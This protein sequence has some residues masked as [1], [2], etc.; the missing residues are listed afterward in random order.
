MARSRCSA[1]LLSTLLLFSASFAHANSS[2]TMFMNFNYLQDQQP[3]GN[4]YNGTGG[5]GTPNYRVSFSSN[6]YGLRSV[7]A[8]INAGSG[9]FSLDPTQTPAI[10]INGIT[11]SQVTGSMNVSNG[12]SSGINFFYA[13]GFQEM[14]QVWSGANGTGTLLATLTLSPNNGSCSPSPAYCN[15]TNVGLSF[16]GVAK[17]VTF[18]GAANGIG[19]TDITLGQSTTV[20]PEPSAVFL[21]ATG[22]FGIGVQRLRRFFPL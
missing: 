6:F 16:T 14:V 22:L 4:F 21:V 12:F 20:M 8:P 17:S 3:V 18:S 13:A 5:S 2:S 7:Y 9:N 1:L 10:F 15:W 11:G 19:I